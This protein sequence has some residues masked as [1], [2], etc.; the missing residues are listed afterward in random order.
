[1]KKGRPYYYVREIARVDGKPKVINQIYLGSPERILEM[2]QG[3][4]SM[5]KKIQAQAFGA[6]WLANLVEK[7]IDLAGLIDG[8]VAEEKD[9]APS[10]G[11]YFLYAVYNRMIQACSKRAMPGWYK[12]TAIQHIRPVQI[13]EL[14]S[15]MFWFKWNQVGERQLQQIAKDFLRRIS[16][17][18]S[19]SSD[20]FM[21]DTTNYYTFMATDTESVLAQRGK[22]KEGRNWLRQIGVAL[23]VSRDK[24][25]PLYYREYEGNR[26]D[27]KM[28][29][30]TMEDM[31]R[32]M[33]DS[34]G[35]DGA[36]TVVFDKG[37]NSEDNIAA[38]DAREGVN[39]ITT[40][41]THYA[42]HL[43]HVDLDRFKPVDTRKNRKLAQK[44]R[45]DDRLLAW[46][47]QGEYWGR[48]RTVVVTYN[49]LTAAKQRYAF[50][51]KMLRLQDTLFEFQSRVNRQAPYW[52]KQSV[53]LKRYMDICSELH[54]PSDLYKV[55]FYVTDKRLRMNFRKNHY[56]IGRYID[57]FGK[58]I[59]IT[60]ITDWSTDEIVQASL[61]RWT[62]EDA[63]RLTKD[64]SQ[65]ALRPVRH[66]TDSKIRCH[67]FT[68]IAALAL[69]RIIELRLRKAGVNMTAKAAMRHMGNLHSCLLWLPGKRK[70]VRMLEEPDE[71]QAD[72]MRAF[73]WKIAGGVLQ[74]I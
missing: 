47:T 42:D 34:A 74:E 41:S 19:S 51:K 55:E 25:I 70:A 68:C 9:N 27:S 32:V 67:I 69:L 15:Q 26:H 29:L 45:E 35:E 12:A 59:I 20:C 3:G 60:N 38:I 54:I 63:F 21:F 65:V 4:N 7:E 39:F 56:R 66:W 10:V 57:R 73:G 17:I 46:R 31:F 1:M 71:A 52:R 6:L 40:Y 16:R 5:P 72:I 61:D 8:I 48:K 43:V 11:E 22:S 23:L 24:R 37:M 30:Q 13:D 49:P 53:V 64:E 36:L 2:A 18:E 44:G 14:N 28:F 50:E 33:R 58:N 62:V